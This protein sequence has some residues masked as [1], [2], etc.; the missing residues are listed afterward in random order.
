MGMEDKCRLIVD[1]MLVDV[2]KNNRM[3]EYL[4]VQARF[5]HLGFEN[6]LLIMKQKP[7][8][9]IVCGKGAWMRYQ[10]KIKEGEKAIALL[11]P[12]AVP[13]DTDDDDNEELDYSIGYSVCPVYDISQVEPT[14]YTHSRLSEYTMDQPLDDVIKKRGF[15]VEDDTDGKIKLKI[16]NSYM[17]ETDKVLYLR[18]GISQQD[19]MRELMAA[20]TALTVGDSEEYRNL[21]ELSDYLCDMLC[22][23]FLSIT[24]IKITPNTPF[25]Q[26]TDSE[27]RE[28]LQTL[29]RMYFEAVQDLSGHQLLDFFETNI[30]NLIFVSDDMTKVIVEIATAVEQADTEDIKNYL[31]AFQKKSIDSDDYLHLK[32]LRDRCSLFTFPSVDLTSETKVHQK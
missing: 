17:D 25:F 23:V 11:G 16:K 32:S 24:D 21:P 1:Q 31:L 15:R 30:C 5:P 4:A 7:D 28:F 9:T 26:Q 27:Q 19:R 20:Y 10:A 12:V 2:I 29:Q 22:Y 6:I 13:L 14:E 18:Q 8:A 3:A